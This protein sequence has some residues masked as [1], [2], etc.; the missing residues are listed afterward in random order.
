MP[1][2]FA[3]LITAV[4]LCAQLGFAAPFYQ[5]RDLTPAGYTTSIAYDIN[6]DGDAVG[7]AGSFSTGSLVEAYFYYDHSTGTSTVFGVGTVVPSDTIV[8]SG[9]RRAAINDSGAIAGTARFV[10][11]VAEPRGF[12]YSGGASGTFTN[13]GVLAG[14][15]ATGIRPSSDAMDIN[16]SGIATGTATSGAGTTPNE[17]DNI[18]VYKGTA[19]PISDIDGDITK[20]TRG[21]YG[22]AL[23]DAGL[24][25]GSN[26]DGKATLFN[27]A[28]ETILLAGTAYDSE[29]S[30]AADLNE[31]SQV[32]GTTI[33]TNN[34]FLY[35]PNGGVTILPQIGTGNRM[36]AKAL[37][38]SGDVVGQGDRTPGLSGQS[39]GFVYLDSDQGSYILEDQVVDL[40]VPAVSG[41]GDWEVL[42]TA[43]AINDSGWIVG[44]GDRRFTGA[45]FPNNRAYLLIPTPEPSG[46]TNDDG[47]YT[48]VDFLELQRGLGTLYTQADLD[49]W[50]AN[51]GTSAVV[52]MTAVPEP[53]CLILLLGSVT[54]V[55]G[56]RRR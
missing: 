24:V 54:L 49:D 29:G 19:S 21:D 16:A 51:Y 1:A 2:K 35:D 8:G 43:W 14:A 48:G 33:V 52:A 9:F 34:A 55:A 42:R 10:G 15:T 11:G 6:S 44:Q 27:G 12:I 5:I 20:I 36:N 40:T 7:I 38:E 23:N 18:D 13:L 37:N 31:S 22:R 45:T 56:R 28:T 47:L 25:A 53:S 3:L 32:V 41:L 30:S 50:E 17:N 46:D 26:Q 4:M 39:R